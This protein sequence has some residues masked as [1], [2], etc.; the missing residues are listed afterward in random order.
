MTK[1]MRAPGLLLVLALFLSSTVPTITHAQKGP[2][3]QVSDDP[4]F[5]GFGRAYIS[6]TY[7]GVVKAWHYHKVQV[8]QFVCIVG[9]V[10]LVLIDTREGSP[11]KGVVNEFFLGVQRPQLVVVPNLVYHG[12]KCISEEMS[13]VVNIPTVPYNYAEPDEF[14]IAPHGTLAYDWTRKDG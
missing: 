14:R 8:D 3:G 11:T 9:M 2:S 12:W 7:P 10:K 6:A 4:E 13:L 1:K 5:A